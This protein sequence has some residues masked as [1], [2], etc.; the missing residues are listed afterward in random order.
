MET[1]T[2]VIEGNLHDRD[3]GDL[4][5]GDVLWM[6]A[7]RGV[8]HNESV[9]TEGH[10]R[11][12]QLWIALPAAERDSEPD[13]EL[14]RGADAPVVRQPGVTAR[15]TRSPSTPAATARVSSRASARSPPVGPARP[16]RTES[17]ITTPSG[18]PHDHH[19]RTRS[20]R[21]DV[22]ARRLPLERALPD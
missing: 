17:P 7:G 10:L 6:S 1:V 18:A 2:L 21:R 4:A 19:H 11:A 9:R 12:L 3:E 5:T 13:Y 16:Q 8:I 22:R 20:A 15:L 14:V